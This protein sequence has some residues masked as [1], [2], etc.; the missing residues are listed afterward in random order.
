[1]RKC[2]WAETVDTPIGEVTL[3]LLLGRINHETTLCEYSD[4]TRE[5]SRY[6]PRLLSETEDKDG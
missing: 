2:L 5:C 6:T 4:P 3:C 1:M